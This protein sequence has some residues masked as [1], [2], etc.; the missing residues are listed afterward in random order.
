[1]PRTVAESN[2]PDNNITAFLDTFFIAPNNFMQLN[3]NLTGR[4]S[5]NIQSAKDSG[6][7]SP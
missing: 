1:M 6:L 3:C 5:L 4:L 7:I 2:P